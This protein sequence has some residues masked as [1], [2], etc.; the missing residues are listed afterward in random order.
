MCDKSQPGPPWR[1]SFWCPAT[2]QWWLC[3]LLV[4]LYINIYTLKLSPGT[5][6]CKH[7]IVSQFTLMRMIYIYIAPFIPKDLRVPRRLKYPRLH[8]SNVSRLWCEP[9]RQEKCTWTLPHCLEQEAFLGSWSN[10]SSY[11]D[12]AGPRNQTFRE[13]S[14]LVLYLLLWQEGLRWPC[15]GFQKSHRR[16]YDQASLFLMS[17]VIPLAR[18]KVSVND[19]ER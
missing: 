16:L 8:C 12:L 17:E 11:A 15:G 1:R 9:A 6:R 18:R 3:S 2:R 7:R 13:L 4:K 5:V 19:P 10:I 14:G